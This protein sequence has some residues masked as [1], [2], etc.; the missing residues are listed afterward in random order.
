MLA[1]VLSKFRA[2]ISVSLIAIFCIVNLSTSS[3][4]FVDSANRAAATLDF[5]TSTFHSFKVGFIRIV[6]SYGNYTILKNERDALRKKLETT[7]DLI[8]LLKYL[9]DENS[10]LRKQLDFQPSV[11][12]PIIHAE[13]IS[14]DPDNLFRTIIV[15]KGSND[16]VKPYMPVIAYQISTVQNPDTGI[17]TEVINYGIV[18]KIIQV[19]K[20]SARILPLTDQ[21]SRVGI[22]VKRTGHW[23]LLSGQSQLHGLPK[24]DYI[25]LDVILH[26][27][28]EVIT[29]GDNGVFPRDIPVGKVT[30]DVFRGATFQDAYL[31]PAIDIEKL[32]TVMILKKEQNNFKT[33]YD[34]ATSS[35]VEKITEEAIEKKNEE[36]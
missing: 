19:T 29:S 24:L 16:G 11:Q 12:Y 5:F 21:Y 4:V 30:K 34:K 26:E 35:E 31:K 15:D 18:G 6:D 27:G 33:Y 25:S 13:I 7:Q 28:D 2:G 36:K 32:E 3:N 20:T 23:G 17:S 8:L 10:R 1:E 22:K 9:E 14:L